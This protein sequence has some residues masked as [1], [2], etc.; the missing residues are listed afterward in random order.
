[1]RVV[2]IVSPAERGFGS[3]NLNSD[4]NGNATLAGKPADCVAVGSVDASDET[5]TEFTSVGRGPTA[6]VKSPP[7]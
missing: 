3:F 7:V 1:M 4:P 2:V 5:V 6:L